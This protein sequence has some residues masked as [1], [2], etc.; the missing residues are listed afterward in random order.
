MRL[1]TGNLLYF[2]LLTKNVQ[3][4]RG[5][6]NHQAARNMHAQVDVKLLL[7]SIPEL[8]GGGVQA[9]IVQQSSSVSV[10]VAS[11]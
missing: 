9:N 10:S 6:G 5:F 3:F 4:L 7:E 11:S 2:L 1:Q 8:G